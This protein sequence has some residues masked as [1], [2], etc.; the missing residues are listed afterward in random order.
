MVIWPKE[1][2][3][4]QPECTDFPSGAQA[5]G[6][7]QG[8]ER[9]RLEGRS[10]LSGQGG[11]IEAGPNPGHLNIR[12]SQER[13]RRITLPSFSFP[14]PFFFPIPFFQSLFNHPWS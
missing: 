12:Q 2:M 6:A 8:E 7:G 13:P 11:E 5:A 4:L 9:W 1:G 10:W 14:H 3:T